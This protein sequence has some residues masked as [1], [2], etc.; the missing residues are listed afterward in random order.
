MSSRAELGFP[1]LSTY[2]P[3]LTHVAREQDL[4]I[5]RGP[6]ATFTPGKFSLPLQAT[7]KLSLLSIRSNHF[8]AVQ[9]IYLKKGH[10]KETLPFLPQLSFPY[11][12]K[13]HFY[14]SPP[15]LS[16]FLWVDFLKTQPC[17]DT[18]A[19]L[20]LYIF[21]CFGSSSSFF[22]ELIT[23]DFCSVSFKV[24]NTASSSSSFISYF[25]SCV[26]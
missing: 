7:S 22:Q 16:L 24:I 9:Y 14:F 25:L 5:R 26:R 15:L 2:R 12:F 19:F 3:C 23:D 10:R 20:P 13:R 11:I 21:S 18:T 4:H 1:V 6:S 17:S 8:S